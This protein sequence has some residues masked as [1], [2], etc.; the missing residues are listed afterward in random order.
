MSNNIFLALVFCVG[1]TGLWAQKINISGVVSDAETGEPIPFANVYVAGVKLQ[2]TTTDFNGRYSLDIEGDADSLE[3]SYVGYKKRKK[4]IGP[5]KK[6]TINFQLSPE[7]VLQEVVVGGKYEN[8]AWEI[9]R[10]AVKNK[11]RNNSD[12]LNSYE[13]RSYV[14]TEISVDNISDEFKKKLGFITKKIEEVARIKGDDGK[15]LIPVFMSESVSD[16]YYNHNP[17]RQKEIIRAAKVDGLGVT[18][19]TTIA[20]LMGSTFQVYNFYKNTV[21][22]AGKDFISP[23]ADTWRVFYDYKLESFELRQ[24]DGYGCHEISFKPKNESDLAFTGK[25]WITDEPDFAIKRIEVTVSDKANLNFI[26]KI[27]IQQ[28]LV[29]DTVSDAWLVAKTRI[30]MDVAELSKN[31]A[32]ML[33][34]FYVANSDFV[35][36]K[37]RPASFFDLDVEVSDTALNTKNDYQWQMLRPD[38]LTT[39]ELKKYEVI[40]E[41]KNIPAVRTI[42]DIVEFFF[43][44]YKTVGPIDLGTYSYAYAF[45]N[46]EGH[47]LRLG[48]RTNEDFSK[49]LV[50]KGYGAYGTLDQTWKFMGEVNLILSRKQW[51]VMGLAHRYDLDQL[52]IYNDFVQNTPLFDAFTRQGTLKRPY[53]NTFDKVWLDFPVSKSLRIKM[54]GFRREFVPHESFVFGYYRADAGGRD[55]LSRFN[56]SEITVESRFAPGESFIIQGN[57]RISQGTKGKPIFTFRYSKGFRYIMGSDFEY[58]KFNFTLQQ[59][60]KMGGLGRLEYSVNLGFTPSPLPYPLLET[61]LGNQS[62]FYNITSFNMMNFFE[63]ASDRF[64]SARAIHRF[65]G[66]FFNRVPLLKKLKWR[67][68]VTATGLL[69]DLSTQNKLGN[70]NRSLTN[71]RDKIYWLSPTLPYIEV[72]YGIENIFKFLR[73]EAVHRLTYLDQPY[74]IENGPFR[75]KFSAQFRL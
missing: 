75:I 28:E 20:Q 51:T 38:T 59:Y 64:V 22:I 46:I 23:L 10:E 15:M 62:L 30:I 12:R 72:S 5:E 7:I 63:F 21:T 6:Q 50:L 57:E 26:E 35:V 60:I 31:S 37:S 56:T 68:F 32:G 8:P 4:A 43:V 3:A 11:A 17:L 65:E 44:G 55:S 18:K 34:K 45:N 25:M 48:F 42:V 39:E 29:Q 66:L 36:N 74:D 33:L 27:K 16:I 71:D 49:K 67:N 9:I 73:I 19:G 41:V 53:F 54:I 24:I 14:R 47:R 1:S 58:D 2:G 70:T 61:H 40:K 69:G 52:A 13:M